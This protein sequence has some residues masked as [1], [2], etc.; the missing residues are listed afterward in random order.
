MCHAKLAHH[1]AKVLLC[2]LHN[3]SHLS[4]T[5][6]QITS[7]GW[8]KKKRKENNYLNKLKDIGY[9]INLVILILK[10]RKRRIDSFK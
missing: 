6:N 5:V 4:S 2:N 1:F 7:I 8:D 3:F 10:S 9:L